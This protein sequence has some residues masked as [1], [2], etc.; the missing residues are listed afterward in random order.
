MTR[1]DIISVLGGGRT[2]IAAIALTG[3]SLGELRDAFAWIG[4]DEALVNEGR[5]MPGARMARLIEIL[6]PRSLR[7]AA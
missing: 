1:E 2:V 6:E 7:I 3:A 5:R 4:V